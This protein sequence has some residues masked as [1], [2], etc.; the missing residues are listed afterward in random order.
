MTKRHIK[1]NIGPA[2]SGGV[3]NHQQTYQ[4]SMRDPEAFWGK[5]AQDIDWYKRWDKVLDDSNPPFYRWFVGGE[6]NTCH[7]AVDR[8]VEQGRGDQ[9]ALIYDSPV[10]QSKRQYTYLELRDAVAHLA[11]ALLAQG[12]KKGDRV[13]IYMPMIPEAVMAMLA[14]ARIGAVHSVDWRC[15]FCGVWWFCG[16]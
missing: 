4:S 13:L 3:V 10:T 6:M 1:S 12:V 15:T 11:G 14:C 9:V 16:Q 7:N 2:I 8:H 5:A